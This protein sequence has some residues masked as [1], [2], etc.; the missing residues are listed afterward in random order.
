MIKELH[1]H[2]IRNPS[3]RSKQ[4]AHIDQ[5]ICQHS[6][7]IQQEVTDKDNTGDGSMAVDQGNGGGQW[8][9]STRL[10]GA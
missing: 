3:S 4:H 6:K 7:P 2:S 10:T 8:V 5:S 1:Q 9:R